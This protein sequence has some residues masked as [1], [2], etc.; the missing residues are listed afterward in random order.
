MNWTKIK[1]YFPLA[2]LGFY[3]GTL[4]L[5]DVKKEKMTHNFQIN[6]MD[7]TAFLISGVEVI[8]PGVHPSFEIVAEV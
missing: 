8:K 4:L 3:L 1:L 5:Y 7:D 6:S 2:E